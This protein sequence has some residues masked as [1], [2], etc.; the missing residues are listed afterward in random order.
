MEL[1]NEVSYQ[2][3]KSIVEHDASY[4]TRNPRAKYLEAKKGNAWKWAHICVPK[5]IVQ[6]KGSERDIFPGPAIKR[7]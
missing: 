3:C 4:E 7:K 1:L 6:Y 5:P 2:F